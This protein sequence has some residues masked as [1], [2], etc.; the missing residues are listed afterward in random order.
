MC[1]GD[2]HYSNWFKFMYFKG[3]LLLN[4]PNLSD[5]AIG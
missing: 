1:I 3:D 5:L 4:I 2:I